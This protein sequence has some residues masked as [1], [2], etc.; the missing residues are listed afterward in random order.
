MI[1]AYKTGAKSFS[2]CV[3]VGDK[4]IVLYFT[5][6]MSESDIKAFAKMLNIN[7]KVK[8]FYACVILNESTAPRTFIAYQD[9]DSQ[10][11]ELFDVSTGISAM[12]ILKGSIKRGELI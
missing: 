11:R 4:E 5:V 7:A 9:N 12:D 3:I 10:D 6:E 8:G 1:E 2:H